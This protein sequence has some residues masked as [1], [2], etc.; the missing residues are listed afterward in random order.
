MDSKAS[1]KFKKF[2]EGKTSK[3]KLDLFF[4]K[5]I[6]KAKN[7]PIISRKPD[8][9]KVQQRKRRNFIIFLIIFSKQNTRKKEISSIKLKEN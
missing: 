8:P 7:S 2:E 5:V 9:L 1:R 3:M 6:H 4:K